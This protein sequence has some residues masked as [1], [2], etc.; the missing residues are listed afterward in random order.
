MAGSLFI[1]SQFLMIFA[2]VKKTWT[3][4]SASVLK[5]GSLIILVFLSALEVSYFYGNRELSK[6]LI[7]YQS[8]YYD[9]V[10]YDIWV[11]IAKYRFSPV[12]SGLNYFFANAGFAFSAFYSAVLAVPIL[13]ISLIYRHVDARV[14]V[15]LVGMIIALLAFLGFSTTLRFYPS[16][17]AFVLLITFNLLGI[18]FRSQLVYTSALVAVVS[19]HLSV[20]IALF[21]VSVG[22]MLYTK[23]VGK[24]H[25]FWQVAI[26]VLVAIGIF[27]VDSLS[28]LQ[29]FSVE[30]RGIRSSVLLTLA[31]LTAVLLAP[32]RSAVTPKY[33]FL[34][35]IFTVFCVLSLKIPALNRLVLLVF[36]CLLTFQVLKLENFSNRV[37]VLSLVTASNL[38]FHFSKYGWQ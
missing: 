25:R 12:W 26:L 14:F 31:I 10:G 8:Y 9:A 17:A 5:V 3:E 22:M 36:I 15:F 6:D 38:V 7:R 29:R 33:I 28:S 27:S 13:C 1:L 35:F 24:T 19:L 37:C 16:G 34:F 4:P 11:Y 20:L 2:Q 18:R 21:L 23:S 32:K 30:S